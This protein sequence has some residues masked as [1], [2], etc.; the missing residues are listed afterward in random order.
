METARTLAMGL[1]A[2][3]SAA[4]TSA[5]AVN[6][7]GLSLGRHYHIESVGQYEP[8]ASRFAVGGSLIDSF[9][10]PVHAGVHFRYIHGN[11]QSGHGGFDGRLALAVPLGDSFSIGLTGRYVS[12]WREGQPGESDPFAEG[13]TFDAA[14]RL[15]PLPGLHIAALGNNL[16][17]LGSGLTARTVGGSASYTFEEVFTLAFDGLADLSTFQNPDGGLRPAGLFGGSAEFFTGEIPI[18]AGYFY[19]TGRD[20]HTVSAGI[21]WMNREVGLDLALRQQVNRTQQT[22]ILASVRYFVQ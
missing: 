14:I 15:T 10:G 11:G 8:Q 9:S 16:L 2:R 20:V 12:L 19:D 17:D 4:S 5:L 7:A 13:F 21:G 6:P 1:G 18:R 22:W 3:A